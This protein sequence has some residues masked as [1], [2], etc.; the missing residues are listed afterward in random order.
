MFQREAAYVRTHDLLEI[1]PERFL[2]VHPSVP[3][4]AAEVLRRVP[5]LVVRRGLVSGQTVPVGTIRIS[6]DP[7]YRRRRFSAETIELCVRWY[8]TYRLSY[9][10]LSAMMAEREIV[11][12]HTTVMRW[13]LRYVPEYE[14]RWARFARPPGSSWRM[15]E[16]AVNV[17]GGDETRALFLRMGLDRARAAIDDVLSYTAERLRRRVA[18]LPAGKHSFTTWLDDD[19]AGNRFWK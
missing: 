6:R 3:E 19:G 16:T 5:F 11:V 4:W 18:A 8:I 2:S 7:I 17:R 14:R 12:S 1:D 13:L 10:D 9:R 15:D